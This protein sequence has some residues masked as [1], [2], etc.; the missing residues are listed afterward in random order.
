MFRCSLSNSSIMEIFPSTLT[1]LVLAFC[2]SPVI[3]VE[4]HGSYQISATRSW[5][6]AFYKMW[7]LYTPA[8][9]LQIESTIPR[10]TPSEAVYKSALNLPPDLSFSCHPLPQILCSSTFLPCWDELW[11][12]SKATAEPAVVPHHSWLSSLHLFIFSP[13]SSF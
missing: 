10:M 8:A 3:G 1:V 4:L 7:S 13:C 6:A 11:P 2:I 5:F 9:P 12:D